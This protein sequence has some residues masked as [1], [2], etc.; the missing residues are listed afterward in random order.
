MDFLPV[1]EEA[2]V[3]LNKFV[4]DEATKISGKIKD[5]REKWDAEY[6]KGPLRDDNMLDCIDAELR[7]IRELFSSAIKTAASQNSSRS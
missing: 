1:I 7:D 6:A 2:L 4:P 3:L 5:F